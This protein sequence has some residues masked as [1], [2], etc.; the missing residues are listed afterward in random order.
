[1]IEVEDLSN[2]ESIELLKS[3]DYAHLACSRND[4]PY[5]VPVHYAWDDGVIFVYTTEG[6]KAEFIEA[7]P[8]VCLQ[9]ETVIDNR[10]GQS[11]IVDG[12]A[13]KIKDGQKRDRAIELIVKINPTLT[14]AVSIRWMDS[15]VR[16]NIEVIYEI[17][18][19]RISGR[20]SVDRTGDTPLVPVSGGSRGKVN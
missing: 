1:M 19:T 16:E 13:E 18:P 7:N 15:W 4:E 2:D 12:T 17:T 8:R 20:R 10:H 9:A 3:M 11:V 14:P 6:K 5:A